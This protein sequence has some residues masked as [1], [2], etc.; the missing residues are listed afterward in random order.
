[1]QGFGFGTL[2]NP[3]F[4]FR[5]QGEEFKVWV[6]K[7]SRCQPVD[8]A[9]GFAFGVEGLEF[10][11]LPATSESVLCGALGFLQYVRRVPF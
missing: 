9:S 6:P 2:K 8:E 5:A 11:G 7:A 3:G 1:M 4:G 10:P